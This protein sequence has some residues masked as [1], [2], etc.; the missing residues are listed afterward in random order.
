VAPV[1][2]RDYRALLLFGLVWVWLNQY[3]I[4]DRLEPQPTIP[5][6]PPGEADAAES[7]IL[8]QTDF[9]DPAAASD[10]DSEQRPD[11][12]TAFSDGRLVVD[13]NNPVTHT[14]AFATMHFTY[15]S[16]VLDVDATKTSGPDSQGIVVVFRLQ[17]ELNYNRF[18]ISP[19]GTYALS[20]VR[21]GEN[22]AVSNLH[23]SPAI[24]TGDSTNHIQIWAVDD[25]FRFLVNDT[26]LTLCI[27]PDAKPYWATDTS[28][29]ET[30]E[31]GEITDTW[32]NGDLMSGVIGLG[33]QAYTGF[34]INTGQESPAL[35]TVTF[36]NLLVRT[37]QGASEP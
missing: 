6:P 18:D 37:P 12:T 29:A 10:W 30:C 11:F 5:P 28:G 34:D 7:G 33:A 27:N 22:I 21:A 20:M 9:N 17:D 36:D 14:G 25:T 31:G 2:S 3:S 1:V 23:P 4:R 8:Y 16:F 32:R 15:E 35:V 13:I 26:P 24:R 19:D